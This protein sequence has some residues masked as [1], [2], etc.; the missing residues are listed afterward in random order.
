MKLAWVTAAFLG[1]RTDRP[2]TYYLR[3]LEHLIRRISGTPWR[4]VV[5]TWERS[6]DEVLRFVPAE[7]VHVGD[8]TQLTLRTTPD[9]RWRLLGCALHVRPRD[10]MCRC[11]DM[12]AIYM[13]RPALIEQTFA[14]TDVDACFWFDCGWVNSMLKRCD[15]SVFETWRLSTAAETMTDLL[16]RHKLILSRTAFIRESL[17][18]YIETNALSSPRHMTPGG[19]WAC[20]RDAIADFVAA[21]A[22][23]WRKLR[24][25]G[26]L[27]DDECAMTLAAWDSRLNTLDEWEWYAI[28]RGEK[29]TPKWTL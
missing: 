15:E 17:K 22:A 13:S 24:A 5:W 25:R 8:P 16:K 7:C 27:Q 12:L 19:A 23:G 9:Y 26:T 1:A 14:D 6:L 11:S 3:P 21:V 4:L 29:R 28:I 10:I 2:Y 20:R 18:S